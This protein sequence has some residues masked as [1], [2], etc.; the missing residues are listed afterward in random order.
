MPAPK[1][2]ADG[3]FTHEE[4]GKVA[5]LLGL[6]L[7]REKFG[8][9]DF[10]E[11]LNV[12]LEHKDVTHAQAIATGKIALA[13][14]RE[15]PDYYRKL[16]QYVEP[17]AKMQYA[18]PAGPVNAPTK[19]HLS[20]KMTANPPPHLSDEDAFKMMMK[21]T[22]VRVPQ[23][24]KD[25]MEAKRPK[26]KMVETKAPWLEQDGVHVHIHLHMPGEGAEL[27]RATTFADLQ[28]SM[29][30][31]RQSNAAGPQNG[32]SPLPDFQA[33]YY[34]PETDQKQL[35]ERKA[36]LARMRAG[37]RQFTAA[38]GWHGQLPADSPQL[39]YEGQKEVPQDSKSGPKT[40]TIRSE[41]LKGRLGAGSNIPGPEDSL[42]DTAKTPR[43]LSKRKSKKRNL[44]RR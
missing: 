25:A 40:P 30:A 16:K 5:D 22:A 39:R 36:R 10:K 37:S 4:A 21:P 13:H 29:L 3:G 24:P 34:G 6:N 35:D 11:G 28:K 14:L 9:S 41:K 12:E 23:K 33:I 7:K 38:F 1:K 18:T 44:P 32:V 42:R 26:A 15:T 19:P 20:G 27:V 43:A 8:L 31:Q 17:S 2:M